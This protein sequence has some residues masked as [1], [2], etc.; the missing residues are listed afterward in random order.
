MLI[1]PF[2]GLLDSWRIGRILLEVI[3]ITGFGI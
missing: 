2:V 1:P 3:A